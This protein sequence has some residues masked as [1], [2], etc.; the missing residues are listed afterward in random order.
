MQFTSS[1][2]PSIIVPIYRSPIVVNIT[3]E[4]TRPSFRLRMGGRE[5]KV[6]REVR[7]QGEGR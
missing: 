3:N 6:E 5:G 4:V 1:L 7:K 2:H